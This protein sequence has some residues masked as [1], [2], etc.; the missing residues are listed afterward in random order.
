[1]FARNV[2]ATSHPLAAQAGL[3]M[4]QIYDQDGRIVSSGHFRN[5]HGRADPTLL[6]ELAQEDGRIVLTRARAAEEDFLA[7]VRT[8]SLRLGDRTFT[9]AE[10]R[11]S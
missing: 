6:D 9:L 11:I 8:S 4:L 5:E 1:M 3:S 7:L 2:V 10:G